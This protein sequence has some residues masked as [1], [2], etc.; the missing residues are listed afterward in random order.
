[1]NGDD[2][3]RKAKF[4]FSEKTKLFILS[5]LIALGLWSSVAAGNLPVRVSDDVEVLQVNGQANWYYEVT[6]SVVHVTY[7]VP[8][9]GNKEPP[10]I[11]VRLDQAKWGD[12]ELA[13]QTFAPTSG[14]VISINPEKVKVHVEPIVSKLMQVD[15]VNMR[16]EPG[17]VIVTGPETAV[18]QVTDIKVESPASGA[19]SMQ[20]KPIPVDKN[21]NEV[22]NVKVSPDLI[23]VTIEQAKDTVTVQVPVLPQF[24][25]PQS[26]FLDNYTVTPKVVTVQGT[27]SVIDSITFIT[28]TKVSVGAGKASVNATLLLPNGVTLVEPKNGRV[29]ISYSAETMT[30]T[31]VVVDGVLYRF[32]CPSQTQITAS[33][34]SV[35]PGGQVQYPTTCVLLGKGGNF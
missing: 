33:D 21:G 22:D 24:D 25:V 28:T 32:I 9:F 5:F 34:I 14:Q 16:V 29:Q 31:D 15:V 26:V 18:A 2:K 8:L 10:V 11:F 6:P 12:Q 20:L 23:T 3:N 27:S 35:S 1:M 17:Q 13:L 7:E 4:K 19:Q 30:A